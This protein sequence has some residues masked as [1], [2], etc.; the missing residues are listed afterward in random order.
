MALNGNGGRI[1]VY[2]HEGDGGDPGEPNVQPKEPEQ[3]ESKASAARSAIVAGI[4]DYGKKAINYGVGIIG[5]LTGDY[6]SQRQ[7]QA[8]ISMIGTAVMMAQFPVGT[9]A[10]AVQLTTQAISSVIATNNA[11]KDVALLRERTGNEAINNSE[12]D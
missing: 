3:R 7:I 4:I 1:D 12:V 6:Q 8:G 5:D 11:N 2:F 10:G 9:I